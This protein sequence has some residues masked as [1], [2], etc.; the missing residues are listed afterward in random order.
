M[1]RLRRQARLGAIAAALTAT[2]IGTSMGAVAAQ[3]AEPELLWRFDFGTATSPV[4]SGWTGMNRQVLYTPERGYGLRDATGMIDR[5]RGSA[6]DAVMRDFVLYQG[7]TYEVMVDVEPG[8]YTVGAVIGDWIGSANTILTVEGIVQERVTTSREGFATPSYPGIRV[9]DGQLNVV[10]GGNTAHLNGL[11]VAKEDLVVPPAVSGLAVEQVA[12]DAEPPSVELTWDPAEGATAYRVYRALDDESPE[13]LAEAT[14]SSHVDVTAE[15]TKHY[16]YLVTWV[17][18][19]GLESVP[20]Q[21]VDVTMLDTT[22]PLP[23]QPDGLAVDEIEKSRLVVTWNAVEGARQYRIHRANSAEGPFELVGTTAGLSFEDTDVLTAVPYFYTVTALNAGGVSDASSVLE[24]PAIVVRQAEYLDRGSVAVRTEA[25][26]FLSWRLLGSDPRDIAFHVYRDGER[27]TTSPIAG[28]TN[29]VDAAGSETSTY[30]ISALG[31]DPNGVETWAGPQFVVWGQQYTS[32]PLDVPEPDYSYISP[33]S[34]Y[35]YSANDASVGDLDGDG[36]YE[37][38]LKWDPSNSKD[39]ASGGTTGPV[40]IDAYKLDGTRLWRV[41]LGGNIR[42]GAHYTQFLVYDFDGNGRAELM[43]KTADGTRD[44][45]GVVIGD[46]DVSYRE[47]GRILKGP[48]FLTVFDGIT[49]AAVDTVDYSPERGDP[50]SWGDS[51][52]NRVDRFLAAVAYLDGEK[53]SAVFARGYY[54]KAE[55]TAYDFD[56]TDITRR[57]EF[58]SADDGNS[59]YGGQGNHNLAVADVDADGK[60]EIVYGSATID[61]DGM[62]LYSTRLRHGDALHV[63]DFDPARPGYEVFAAHEDIG[64]NGG[65]GAT[66]RDARTGEVIWNMKAKVDVGRGAAG[67]IDPRHPGAEGWAVNKTGEWNSR[68]GELRSASGELISNDIPA[69]NFLTWWDGDLLRE[70]TDHDFDET[71]KRGVGT[72]SKWDWK[73]HDEVEIFRAEGTL[74]NNSTKGNAVV[75]ADLLG[76]WREELVY[77]TEDS[78]E[79]RLYTTVDPTEH[80]IPTLMHDPVYRLGVAWQNVGYNQPP[81]TSFFLGDGMA[82]A[83]HPRATFI[84]APDGLGEPVPGDAGAAPARAKL[85]DDNGW[86]TGLDDGA[87]TVSMNLW[88]GDNATVYRLFENGEL[89]HERLLSDQTPSAQRV[90]VAVSGRANGDYVYT[91]E[92]SNQ[93]GTTSCAEH[94]VSVTDAGPG[95]PSLSSDNRDGDGDYSVMMN[96]WWG[97][98]G[99][100]YRLYEDGVLIDTQSLV[101]ATPGAQSATTNVTGRAPGVHVYRAELENALGVTESRQLE[102]RV[103]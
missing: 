63:S 45:K 67:D 35:S 90:D 23:A 2:M 15:L 30:R 56:G 31:V 66:F 78:S 46:P 9:V 18:A 38:V 33:S 65:I 85:S 81:H 24:T 93:H 61:D 69:P 86:D 47:G 1:P 5:D 62:G 76:D 6:V 8:Y 53:P 99:S 7:G 92:V 72:I 50:A 100:T 42:A 41:N 54:S 25:G 84:G 80:R 17:N 43:A 88:W 91:C 32:I 83:P 14:G 52:G 4:E 94:T 16:S 73:A 59:A 101:E 40:I 98:N 22:I 70:I 68:E 34:P 64:E 97:T 95:R 10:V 12:L 49:G 77:R 55:L 79:L 20:S 3:A 102:V 27:I 19:E 39:N 36:Q 28:A 11:T 89:I 37:I 48:E 82:P 44:G 71:T 87:Y 96:L 60:D 74:T 58:S 57:W 51:R 29:F 75:Q 21:S 26:V 13:L 103:R